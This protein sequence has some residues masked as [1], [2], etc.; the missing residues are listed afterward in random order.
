[1]T[2]SSNETVPSVP[3]DSKKGKNEGSCIKTL[4]FNTKT[5]FKRINENLY[6]MQDHYSLILKTLV[7]IH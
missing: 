6:K 4:N 1:M 7:K 5:R 2:L 3:N